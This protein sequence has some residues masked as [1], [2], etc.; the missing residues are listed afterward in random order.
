MS[1]PVGILLMNGFPR[2]PEGRLRPGN[3]ANAEATNRR[4]TACSSSG[5]IGQ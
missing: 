3:Q 2:G 1:T 4:T 5:G